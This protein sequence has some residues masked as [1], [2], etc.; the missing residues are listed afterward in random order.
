MVTQTF[1]KRGQNLFTKTFD[2]GTVTFAAV[3]T[4]Q[5]LSE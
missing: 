4:S 1:G 2:F 3:T 5:R